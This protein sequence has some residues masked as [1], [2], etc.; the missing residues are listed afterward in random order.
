MA[1]A[2]VVKKTSAIASVVIGLIS[3]LKSC[4]D[5]WEAA[6]YRIGGRNSRNT[7]SGLNTKEGRDGM[8]AKLNPAATSKT[9]L[10]NF[11]LSAI[12]SK[13]IRHTN[14]MI[15]ISKFCIVAVVIVKIGRAHH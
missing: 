5:I 13:A 1:T 7:I 2:T 6:S 8:N 10:G 14:K 3:D 15:M 9:G 11:N 12:A 4:H